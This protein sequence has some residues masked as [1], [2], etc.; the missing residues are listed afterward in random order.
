MNSPNDHL[1]LCSSCKTNPATK[2]YVLPRTPY[3]VCETCFDKWKVRDALD[4]KL[5]HIIDLEQK[6]KYDEAIDCLNEIFEANRNRDHDGWLAENVTHHRAMILFEA[7]RYVEAEQA[8]RSWAKI[9]FRSLWFRQMWASGL[10]QVLEAMGRDEEAVSVIEDVL[11]YHDPRDEILGL[12]LWLRMLR[13]SEKLGR[14]VEPKWVTFP[15]T[16]AKRMGLELPVGDSPAAV[17]AALSELIGVHLVR[18]ADDENHEE[19]SKSDSAE[20]DGE[21]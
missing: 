4:S 1:V 16:V 2:E 7:G 6:K 18:D 20:S 12:Q 13:L 17:V 19:E 10:A 21:R 5:L 3:V 9:G 8:L 15:E 14:P 11:Q